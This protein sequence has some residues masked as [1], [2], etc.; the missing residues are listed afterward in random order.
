MIQVLLVDDHTLVRTALRHLLEG[1]SDIRVVAEAD[2]GEVALRSL[3]EVRVDAVLMDIMMPGMGGLEAIRRMLIQQPGLAVVAIT[4]SVDVA[5]PRRLL[6][7]GVRA[8]VTKDAPADEL[9]EALRRAVRG[10]HYVSSRIA[11]EMALASLPSRND[12]FSQLSQREMQVL[13]M[14]VEGAT[15]R[16]I[17]DRLLLSP[18]TVSTYRARLLEKLGAENDIELLRMAMGRGLVSMSPEPSAGGES[19]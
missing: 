8:Y 3:R 12:P 19:A 16:Q 2:S 1:Q 15:N 18:K 17:S 10:E 11:R 6:E 7:D 4:S 13:M 14:L 9:I 5:V